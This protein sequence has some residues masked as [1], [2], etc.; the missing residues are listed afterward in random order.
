M[1]QLEEGPRV[2]PLAQQMVEVTCVGLSE[3]CHQGAGRVE[4]EAAM[5]QECGLVLIPPWDW[6]S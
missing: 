5:S 1:I 3:T 4:P 6:K 2:F